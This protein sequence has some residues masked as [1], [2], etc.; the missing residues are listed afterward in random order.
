LDFVENKSAGDK[1]LYTEVGNEASELC[2]VL[3]RGVTGAGKRPIASTR[4]WSL[5]LGRAG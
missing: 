1:N 5:G 4:D 2:S 3:A